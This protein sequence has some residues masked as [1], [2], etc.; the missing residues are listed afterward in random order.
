M[1]GKK[2]SKQK[3][4]LAP[5]HSDSLRRDIEGAE[6]EGDGFD[7]L[8]ADLLATLDARDAAEAAIAANNSNSLNSS[9]APTPHLGS[10][11]NPDPFA[12]PNAG[13]DE[14]ASYVEHQKEEPAKQAQEP[15]H[16]SNG[17]R[18]TSI[19]GIPIPSI[20][21]SVS[22]SRK[23]S[24]SGEGGAAAQGNSPESPSKRISSDLKAAGT[25]S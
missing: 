16:S 22:R 18:R 9:A 24:V 21:V 2:K 4:P 11:V 5:S 13:V 17:K 10:S 23:S 19:V 20:S 15:E 1:P 6:L 3:R 7:D 25:S 8:A 12:T 14:R